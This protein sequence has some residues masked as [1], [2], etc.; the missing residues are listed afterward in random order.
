MS[1]YEKKLCLKKERL[2][3]EKCGLKW[4]EEHLRK[5]L[6]SYEARRNEIV[7]ELHLLELIDL[8]MFLFLEQVRICIPIV[9]LRRIICAY[10]N[11]NVHLMYCEEYSRRILYSAGIT[12]RGTGFPS[13]NCRLY[14]CNF[15]INDMPKEWTLKIEPPSECYYVLWTLEKGA[16]KRSHGLWPAC[17]LSEQKSDDLLPDFGYKTMSM[18]WRGKFGHIPAKM[19]DNVLKIQTYMRSDSYPASCPA[20]EE[21]FSIQNIRSGRIMVIVPENHIPT[22]V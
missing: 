20:R 11:E 2:R 5:I 17:K 6:L 16:A 10:A 13:A 8:K 7:E 3:S 22:I 21:Q 18:G 4:Q 19:S 12:Y 15:I 9:E 14:R 1:E